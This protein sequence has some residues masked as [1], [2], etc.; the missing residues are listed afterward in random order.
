MKTFLTFIFICCSQ[1]FFATNYYVSPNGNDD[2]SGLTIGTS[3]RTIERATYA[4]APGDTV[5]IRNGIYSKNSPQSLIA[6]LTISGTAGNPITF[7]NYPGETPVLQMNSNNWAGFSVNGCDYIT[8]D[9]ITIIGNNDNVTLQYA[10]EQQLNTG[11]TATSG[12][13]IAIN[14]QYQNST[15]KSHH[16]IVKNCKISKCGGGGIYTY[17]ADYITIENN[18]VS[19]CGWYAPF[20]NS[21]I[22]MYQNINSDSFTGFKNFIIG[23]TCF[24]NENLIPFFVVGSITDG[25][26]I[27][28]DDS[29]NTQNNS[30]AGVYNAKTYIANNLVFDNGG[31]GIHCFESDNVLVINNTSYQNCRSA[32]IRQGE[33]TAIYTSNVTF[34]NNIVTPSPNVPPINQFAASNIVATNNLFTT[35]ASLANPA[36]INTIVGNAGFVNASI[37][38]SNANFRLLQN[39]SAINAGTIVNAPVT[40]KDGNNRLTNN[41]V[42]IGC[43]EFQNILGLRSFE[44][45]SLTL[46]PNPA[47]SSFSIKVPTNTGAKKLEIE[48]L[49]LLGQKIKEITL[50]N[51]IDAIDV[52]SLKT[53]TYVVQIL[54]N[55]TKYSSKLLI[56]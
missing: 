5:L 47:R 35:N 54:I 46:Y 39:S 16:V 12:S 4:V 21:G 34:A 8:I 33:L 42:D 29:R 43:Y 53:G 22:S 14:D 56:Q 45:N 23:N 55:E 31:K 36:G 7:K 50:D 17:N 27:I 2:N 18:I 30:N 10:Q 24:K 52:S 44:Q 15:N 6:F 37:N 11:N 48:I 38:F 9:G 28:I 40:D 1:Y 19:E 3:F 41:L 49:D 20:A 51:D 32:S 25:N 26:G 13:G